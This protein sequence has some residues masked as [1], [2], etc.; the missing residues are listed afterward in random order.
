MFYVLTRVPTDEILV[1]RDETGNLLLSSK[2]LE[3]YHLL[4]D[5]LIL[6]HGPVVWHT[7]Q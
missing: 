1:S 5:Q 2:V 6:P 4:Q 3:C 7:V